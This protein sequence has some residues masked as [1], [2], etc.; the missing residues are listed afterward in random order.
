MSELLAKISKEPKSCYLLGDFN[1]DLLKIRYQQHFSTSEFLDCMFSHSFLPLISQATRITS[2]TATL[3][4]NIFTNHLPHAAINGI[5]F[6]DIS[7]HLPIFTLLSQAKSVGPR[8]TVIRRVIKSQD[9][10]ENFNWDNL[11]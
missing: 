11:Y 5:F 8:T 1:F 3:I 9:E 10:L 7:D 2:H 6:A 4:D